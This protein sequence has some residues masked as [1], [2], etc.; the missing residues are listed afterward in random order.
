MKTTHTPGPWA[1]NQ[2]Y[3]KV[4][5]D[6]KEIC[7]VGVNSHV[8]EFNYEE[9]KANAK[10]IAAAPELLEALQ[11]LVEK[12]LHTDGYSQKVDELYHAQQ[13]IQKAKSNL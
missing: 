2:L 1:T 12:C 6:D 3:S 10:L 7:E 4:L 9:Y 13:A 8:E 5:A 11:N